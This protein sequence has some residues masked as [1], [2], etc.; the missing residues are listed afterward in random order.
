LATPSRCPWTGVLMLPLY[1]EVAQQI[2]GT[3]GEAARENMKK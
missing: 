2:R 3:G 1:Q